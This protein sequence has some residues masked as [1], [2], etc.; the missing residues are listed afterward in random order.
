MRPVRAPALLG[1]LLLIVARPLRAQDTLALP[2]P[3]VGQTITRIDVRTLPPYFNGPLHRWPTLGRLV[4]ELH[5]TTNPEVVRRFVLLQ[6]GDA[7]DEA[8]R[9]ESERILRVQPYLSSARITPYPDGQGGVVLRVTTVDEVS[10]TI[11]AGIRS[12]A[13]YLS[14]FRLGDQNAGGNAISVAAAW[15]EGFYYRDQFSGRAVDYQLFGRPY[16]LSIDGTRRTLGGEWALAAS[17][18][19]FTDFQ[20][21][22]W[23]ATQGESRI[24]V[25]F[26]RGAG[27][28][29]S[30]AVFRTYRD[31][32]GVV[33][34]GAPGRLSLFGASISKETEEPAPAPV[35]VTDRGVLPDSSSVLIGRYVPHRAARANLLWGVRNIHFLPVTGFD[36]L[37]A[38]QDVRRGFELGTVFGRSL[39]ILGSRD[40]DIFLSADLYGGFGT[41]HTFV[42]FEGLGE[43]RQSYD[44][45]DWDGVLTSGRLAMYLRPTWNHT[46]QTSVEWGAGWNQR[47]PF[48]L[49][50]ADETGGVRGFR[51]SQAGGSQ[52][53]VARLED[54]W[55]LGQAFDF[56]DYGLA[57]F[58]DAGKLWAGDAPFGVTTPVRY[59]VGVGFLA[60]VPPHS[61]R[62]WRLDVAVPLNPDAHTRGVEI[63]LT[64]ADRTRAFWQEPLDVARV[65]ERSVPRSIFQWP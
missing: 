51:R 37:T 33:R 5:A 8:R 17:H 59:S 16:Q 34:V 36:A 65:R 47:V 64:N 29:P 55:L 22:A 53:V 56:A 11:G 13:P 23:S 25:P 43:G 42:A 62:L 45:N 14:S 44:D 7:C 28:D 10:T 15:K 61:K 38:T 40:D 20:R 58:G 6:P 48:Q 19:F 18:P 31:V 2:V 41:P 4:R 52:R 27:A 57:L 49:T 30:L 63:R 60:A 35:L 12:S 24:Y 46:I 3:C 32:G 39:A 21:I 9:A 26:L 1:A 54:H 50:L